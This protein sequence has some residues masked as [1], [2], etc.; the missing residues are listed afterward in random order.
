MSDAVR[1]AVEKTVQSTVGSA[2][3]TRERAQDLVD[4]VVRRAEQGAARAGRGV[5]EAGHRQAEAAAGVG[6]RLRDAIPDLRVAT[7]EDVRKV[8]A[9]L[10]RLAGRVD[11]LERELRQASSSRSASKPKSAAKRTGTKGRTTAGPKRSKR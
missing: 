2:T 9:D 10:E 8:A 11:R 4:D 7:R 5:R 1:R 3:M 6:D